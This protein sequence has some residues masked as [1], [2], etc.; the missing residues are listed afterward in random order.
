MDVRALIPAWLAIAVGLAP[1]GTAHA[2]TLSARDSARIVLNRLAYGPRPGDID[3]VAS[4][5]V[6]RWIDAQLKP[7][8]DPVREEMEKGFDILRLDREELASR[9]VNARLAR[10]TA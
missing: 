7:G 1:V 5:G 10:R 2:Q 4:M 9:F 3:R 8:K 6:M